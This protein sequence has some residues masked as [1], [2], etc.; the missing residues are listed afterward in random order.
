MNIIL[1][2][3]PGAGKGTQA[4]RLVETFSYKQMSTGDLVRAEIASGSSTGQLIKKVIDTGQ[5]TSDEVIIRLVEAVYDPSVQGYIFDGFP[6]T[7]NQ[8]QVLE[9][10]LAHKGQKIDLIICLDVDDEVVIKRILGRYSCKECG[11]I[12]NKYFQPT[13]EEGVCDVCQ[14]FDFD[15]RSDD[16]EQA[17]QTRLKTY[18]SMTEPVVQ[19]FEGKTKTVSIDGS[20]DIQLIFDQIK[21]E[22]ENCE[23]TRQAI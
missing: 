2:G 4:K 14:S 8:A 5:F 13:Q 9:K 10:M 17:I 1:F 18:H 3:A 12:Y 16:T 19:Y 6:R 22:I 7:A 11:A 23:K 15:I 21:D 20:Q